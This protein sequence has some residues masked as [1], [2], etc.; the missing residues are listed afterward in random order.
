VSQFN[1]LVDLIYTTFF[2]LFIK[3]ISEAVGA[4]LEISV[5]NYCALWVANKNK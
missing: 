2:G 4:Y 5:F 1:G 3:G